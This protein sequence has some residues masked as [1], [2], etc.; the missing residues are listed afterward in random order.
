MGSE[1]LKSVCIGPFR[2]LPL[3][4]DR[5]SDDRAVSAIWQLALPMHSIGL[6]SNKFK[7]PCLGTALKASS[8]GIAHPSPRKCASRPCLALFEQNHSYRG[9]PDVVE[10]RP[11]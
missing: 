4:H 9:R 7:S 1:L 10:N 11:C 8:N 2:T 5:H 6:P 3:R